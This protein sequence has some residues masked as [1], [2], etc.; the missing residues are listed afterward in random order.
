MHLEKIQVGRDYGDKLKLMSGLNE[1]ERI[2][3][4][5]GGAARGA[6]GGNRSRSNC[7]YQSRN[8]SISQISCRALPTDVANRLPSG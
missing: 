2:I 5:P 4:N 1:G 3:S 7:L 6:E 8:P